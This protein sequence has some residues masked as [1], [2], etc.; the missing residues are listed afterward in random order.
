M[1]EYYYLWYLE[2]I[3]R[4]VK[5]FPNVNFRHLIMPEENLISSEIPIF[6]SIEVNF[7]LIAQGEKDARNMLTAYLNNG[8]HHYYFDETDIEFHHDN[9]NHP[10]VESTAQLFGFDKIKKLIADREKE[11]SLFN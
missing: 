2:D 10:E 5:G 7:E 8:G 4:I 6:D 1:F 9:N 3:L 11:Q